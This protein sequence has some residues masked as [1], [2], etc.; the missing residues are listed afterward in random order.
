MAKTPLI[1]GLVFFLTACI[2]AG[3][4]SPVQE[5]GKEQFPQMV[6]IDL[7]GQERALPESFKGKYQIVT[8]AFEREQQ[9]LVNTWIPFAEE[10]EENFDGL[11]FYEVPLI[12]ELN[13]PYRFWVNNGMRAGIPNDKA[14]ER[15]ITIYTDRDKFLNI[16]GM[17]TEDIYTLLLDDQGKILWQQKGPMTDITKAYLLIEVKKLYGS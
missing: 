12:Y 5:R 8:V 1:L 10:L 2:G 4:N 15:T 3:T 9:D 11:R 6:G 17:K 13:A 16:T 7:L 14:R